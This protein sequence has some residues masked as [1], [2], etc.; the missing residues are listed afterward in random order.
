MRRALSG[1]RGGLI[2][3]KYKNTKECVILRNDRKEFGVVGKNE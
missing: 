1:G 3:I 2:V